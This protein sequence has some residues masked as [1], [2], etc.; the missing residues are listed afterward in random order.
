MQDEEGTL[1]ASAQVILK[2]GDAIKG[3]SLADLD[4]NFSIEVPEEPAESMNIEIRMFGYANYT[5]PLWT[6]GVSKKIVLKNAAIEIEEIV[7]SAEALPLAMKQDTLIYD[8]DS[9]TDGTE[10]KV[11]DMLKKLPGVEVDEKGQISVQG[12]SID[13]VLIDGEDAFGSNYR[14]ATQNINA[15]FIDRV[16]VISNFKEDDLTGDLS[17]DEELV[18]NLNLEDSRKKLIFGE[19]TLIHGTPDVSMNDA[20]L[21]MLS[22]KTKSILFAQNNTAGFEP[23][24]GLDLAYQ[25][26]GNISAF[27]GQRTGLLSSPRGSRPKSIGS[28][29]Y[30]QNEVYATAGSLLF[31]PSKKVKSRTIFSL[32]NN[33]FR[34]DNLERLNFFNQNFPV[35]V[36][37]FKL[38][39]ES[40]GSAW[41]DNESK[42]VLGK[43]SRLDLDLNAMLSRSD[44]SAEL[45]SQTAERVNALG[46]SLEGTPVALQ[47]DLRYTL[48]ATDLLAF[49]FI[50][51]GNL[52]TNDQVADYESDRYQS[53]FPQAALGLRQQAAESTRGIDPHVEVLYN[54]KGWFLNGT[55]GHRI[56]GGD[57][58][59]L[60]TSLAEEPT[61]ALP[62][63]ANDLHYKFDETYLESTVS[64]TFGKL[65]TNGGLAI[66][67][68]NLW[69]TQGEN[70]GDRNFRNLLF[71]PYAQAEYEISSRSR[72]SASAELKQELPGVNQLVSVP[73]LS[74]YQTLMTGLDTLYLQ[75]T[76]SFGLRYN[77]NNTFRQLSYYV[78]LQ[79]TRIP[80]GLQRSLSVEPLFTL[81]QL[82]AG[83]PSSSLQLRGGISKYIQLIKGSV[84]VKFKLIRFDNQLNLNQ[85]LT[86]NRY[87]IFAGDLR[88]LS[89]VTDWL[90]FSVT[91][92]YRSAE[93]SQI[94]G[95]ELGRNGHYTY[96]YNSTMT[97]QLA[98]QTS[99]ALRASGFIWEQGGQATDVQLLSFKFRC[100]ISDRLK[101][102]VDGLNLLNQG[103]F[104]QNL[105]NSYQISQ[106][107]FVLRPRTFMGGVRWSF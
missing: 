4:G 48:R 96:T 39:R 19:L 95:P 16:D 106:R 32:D 76:S 90:K 69:Y 92:G 86:L 84:E 91:L 107:S 74:D 63:N 17:N 44:L 41:I 99:L 42:I 88:Y 2:Q 45:S 68:S 82:E 35:T 79:R 33:L 62:Q 57:V 30:L 94:G 81:Q 102:H 11:E 8:T 3:Y 73:Y 89:T 9:F 12:K 13:R 46:T 103:E 93:N 23:T 47:G 61:D 80:N 75:K 54:Y 21:F 34:L 22:G 51:T 101:L 56:T 7:I 71:L 10:E 6:P 31:N 28:Q 100:P 98:K 26:D 27:S 53:L 18:L 15:G 14:L 55:I 20:N 70:G 40:L 25:M 43:K 5:L 58:N 59:T 60:L 36:D 87:Q 77:Y 104:F 72:I 85:E 37:N 1:L 67:M 97:L 50:L 105:V 24:S 52:N 78:G 29:E 49:R 66:S 65:E 83:F 64:R 38:Y